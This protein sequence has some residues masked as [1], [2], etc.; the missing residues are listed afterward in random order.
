MDPGSPKNS[1]I[2]TR[3][4]SHP[5]ILGNYESGISFIPTNPLEAQARVDF[6]RASRHLATSCD[7]LLRPARSRPDEMIVQSA[8][9]PLGCW[10]SVLRR[11]RQQNQLLSRTLASISTPTE[12]P[13]SN[14]G[15]IPPATIAARKAPKFHVIP[16]KNPDNPIRTAFAVYSPP[17][18]ARKAHPAALVEYHAQQIRR[19]DRTGARTALFSKSNPDAAKPGDVLQVTTNRGEP[20]AGACLQIRRAGV[21]TAILLR[22]TLTKVGVEMWYKIYSPSVLGIE[23]IW[24]RP[25][26]ARRARLMHMRRAK[27]DMGNVDHLVEAWRRARNVF[28]SR[29]KG[30]NTGRQGKNS[31]RR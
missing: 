8:R 4:G 19:L 21:D 30:G 1:S 16:T 12:P 7:E 6:S 20:F 17:P 27:H 25:K 3:S 29:G 31:K 18:S 24:R 22:N 9:R 14:A 10:K 23:I 11:S 2:A 5:E 15:A 28:S 13:A 26:R